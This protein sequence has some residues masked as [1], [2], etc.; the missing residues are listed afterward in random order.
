MSSSVPAD[1]LGK[2][3]LNAVQNGTYP[4]SE[5]IISA[6][7]SP[8]AFPQ[9]LELFNGARDE[10]KVLMHPR[11]PE[12]VERSTLIRPAFASQVRIALRTSMAGYR[13][14]SSCGETSR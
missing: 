2:A 12:R 1:Q 3:V 5:E 9:A 4:D 11:H 8:S 13:K 7:F 6:N 10:V 14:Q